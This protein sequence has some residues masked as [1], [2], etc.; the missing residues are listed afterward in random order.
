M[1]KS[2]LFSLIAAFTVMIIGIVI[3]VT[4]QNKAAEQNID[5][6]KDGFNEDGEMVVT[7]AADLSELDKINMILPEADVE[8]IGCADSSR[9][10]L[11]NFHSRTYSVSNKNGIFE[12]NDEFSVSSLLNLSKNDFSF[13]GIRSL[14]NLGRMFTDSKKVR[15]YLSGNDDIDLS[16]SVEKGNVSLTNSEEL[17]DIYIAV[18]EGNVKIYGTYSDSATVTVSKGN[19][20]LELCEIKK[21]S[22]RLREG[23]LK[24]EASAFTFHNF[25]A[26]TEEG[27]VNVAGTDSGRSYSSVND[28]AYINASLFTVKGNISIKET[29]G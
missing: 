1:K 11:V 13:N 24:Y 20:D 9:I 14:F 8:I 29:Q 27:T 22:V 3:C 21:L 2:F 19:C 7:Y 4:A 18:E 23:N 5:L 6:F 26:E 17:K 28:L 25:T 16:L 12:F 15:I 10:E